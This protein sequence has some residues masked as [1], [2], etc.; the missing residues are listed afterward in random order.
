MRER[1]ALVVNNHEWWNVEQGEGGAAAEAK[2]Q[3][4]FP[5]ALWFS[6]SYLCVLALF[7]LHGC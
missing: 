4:E 2:N 7:I 6:H 3:E 1:V 5:S